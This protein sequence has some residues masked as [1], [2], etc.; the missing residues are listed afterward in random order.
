M[1]IWEEL[2][3]KL[4]HLPSH[5]CNKEV[6]DLDKLLRLGGGRMDNQGRILI[7]PVLREAAQMKGDVDVWGN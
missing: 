6:P 1:K 7:P 4:A 5:N 3:S 2:E